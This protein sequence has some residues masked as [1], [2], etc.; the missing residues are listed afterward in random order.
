MSKI[1]MP[2][3]KA[4]ADRSEF[5]HFVINELQK[6]GYSNERMRKEIAEI[7]FS[8]IIKMYK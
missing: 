3:S 7:N 4:L 5:P 2:S 6:N 1:S 8:E